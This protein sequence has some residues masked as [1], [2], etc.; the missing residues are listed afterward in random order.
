MAGFK[1]RHLPAAAVVVSLCR[2]SY[3]IPARGSPRWAPGGERPVTSSVNVESQSADFTRVKDIGT[4]TGLSPG[5]YT[6]WLVVVRAGGDPQLI[7]DRLSNLASIS[8]A[9]Q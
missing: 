1:L 4:V 7:T 2:E 9:V 3:G 8:F 5:I 6:L